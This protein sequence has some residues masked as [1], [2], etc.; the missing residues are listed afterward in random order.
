MIEVV[1]L[2]M[3]LPYKINRCVLQQPYNTEKEKKEGVSVVFSIE[4]N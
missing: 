2:I 1:A 3:M 4:L